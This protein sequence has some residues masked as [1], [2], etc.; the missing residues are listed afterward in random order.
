MKKL[1]IPSFICLVLGI[2][3]LSS[4]LKDNDDY[5]RPPQG[6]MTFING[7]SDPGHVYFRTSVGTLPI[8]YK[9]FSVA[10]M[11]VGDRNLSIFSNNGNASL[12]DTNLVIKD[13]TAYSSVIYGN[14]E[15]PKFA[16]VEDKSI[17]NLGEQSGCRFLNLANGVGTVNLF[18]GSETT[19]SFAN[20]PIETGA[21][22]VSNQTFV[23][24]ASGNMPLK[25]TDAD[26]NTIATRTD[27]TFRKGYY[28]TVILIG[29]KDNT[30]TPLYLGIVA[31]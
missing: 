30:A 24:K 1:S 9:G 17:S 18:L 13:S 20:R 25:I 4:C 11:L 31:H 27:Y 28:Y 5:V 29:T 10:S 16:F 12:I 19:A 21:T 6:Y 8:P 23:A 3:T 7:F 14:R 2:L 26:G 15:S 22:A